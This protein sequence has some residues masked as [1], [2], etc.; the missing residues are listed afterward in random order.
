MLILNNKITK[1]NYSKYIRILK[2]IIINTGNFI[3]YTKNTII[4]LVKILIK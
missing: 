3:Y 4:T 2:N 1:F